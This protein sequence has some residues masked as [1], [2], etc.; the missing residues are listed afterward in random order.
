MSC[1]LISCHVQLCAM[2]FEKDRFNGKNAVNL[3]NNAKRAKNKIEDG[4]FAII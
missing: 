4:L 2:P 1:C 3:R